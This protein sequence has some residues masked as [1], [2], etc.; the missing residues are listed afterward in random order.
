MNSANTAA[1]SPDTPE[2]QIVGGKRRSMNRS[3]IRMREYLCRRLSAA[4]RRQKYEPG[5]RALQASLNRRLTAFE[6]RVIYRRAAVLDP[7]FK[8]RWCV[9]RES[10]NV[11]A[12]IIAQLPTTGGDTQPPPP[13]RPC[14]FSFMNEADN[15]HDANN[16]T[17]SYFNERCIPANAKPLSYWRDNA[18]RLPGLALLARRFLNV[19]A[20]SAPVE[21]LFSTAGKMFR[22]DRARLTDRQFK[23]LMYNK[24]NDHLL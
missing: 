24:C 9:G 22:P 1:D 17:E 7:R 11:K 21:R 13:K 2:R 12:D 4:R 3:D 14:L 16:E 18:H 8:L 23:I 5:F 15:T 10:G 6:E 20:S 19:T